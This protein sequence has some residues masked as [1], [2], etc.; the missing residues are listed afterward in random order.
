MPGPPPDTS[1]DTRTPLWVKVCGIIALVALLFVI[2]LFT[3]GG[4]HGPARHTSSGDAGGQ[5]PLSSVTVSGGVGG[6]DPTG[7]GH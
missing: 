1:G 3:S 7:R 2:L 5:T 4:S 6:Y